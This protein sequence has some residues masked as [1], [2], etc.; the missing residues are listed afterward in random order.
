MIGRLHN[1]SVR[2][3]APVTKSNSVS[4]ISYLCIDY[5]SFNNNKSH[6]EIIQTGETVCES[7][8]GISLVQNRIHWRA[9]GNMMA[10]NL[11]IS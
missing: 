3:K 1:C 8:L 10:V 4:H 6:S 2:Q 11:R 7:E 5:F 9:L